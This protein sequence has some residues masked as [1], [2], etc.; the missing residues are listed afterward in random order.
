VLA[1]RYVYTAFARAIVRGVDRQWTKKVFGFALQPD[2]VF[3]MRISPEDLIPRVI[4]SEMLQKRYREEDQGE[5]MDY[6][7]SG[8]DMH[9]G[10]DFYDSFVEYQKKVLKEFDK[11]S[12]LFSFT[13]IDASKSFDEVNRELKQGILSV[14]EDQKPDGTHSSN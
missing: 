8:M 13:N 1:D 4:N 12:K 9:L 3:Y 10:K 5:G 6:W 7:E 14:I 2:A 11:M